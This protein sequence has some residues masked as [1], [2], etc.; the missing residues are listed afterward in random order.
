MLWTNLDLHC[1]RQYN[2]ETTSYEEPC[3]SM[4]SFRERVT[5][6]GLSSAHGAYN[7]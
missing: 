5:G 2:G 1:E 3:S 4:E 7:F 6:I